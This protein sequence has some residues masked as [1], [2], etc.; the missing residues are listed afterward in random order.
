MMRRPRGPLVYRQALATR[1]SHWVWAICL[2]FLLL[3]GLQIF[4]AHPALYLGMQSGFGFD[5]TI[6]SVGAV[7]DGSS[8][9]GV[10]SVF[11]HSFDTT[12]WLGAISVDG[13][14]QSKSFPGWLTVP[15]YRDLASGRVVHFFFAW[16][17]VAT[18]A[19]WLLASFANRHL[20]RDLLPSRTDLA[21]IGTD[22]ADHARLRLRHERR[23]G[24]LQKLSYLGV[25]FVLLPVM[26]L[27][28]LTMSPGVNAYAPWMLDLFG[29][30]QTARTVHFAVMLLLVAFFAVH[31]LM[32][33]LAG[34]FNEL[35]SMTTGW[36]RIDEETDR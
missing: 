16:I 34:P 31:I 13:D 2:F 33:L 7:R 1:L 30:R 24:V 29:G 18:L 6:L 23:Y 35:R 32:V 36:F 9:Q 8:L 25:M 4:M 14:L 12:G 10:T 11:G 22:I 27:S 5:N 21:E 17:L 19:V 26:I 28:G 20:T 3:S 15:S